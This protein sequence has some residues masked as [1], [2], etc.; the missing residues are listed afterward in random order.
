MGMI[1]DIQRTCTDDGPGVRTTVFFKGCPLRCRWCH[2]PESH[3]VCPQQYADTGEMIGYDAA[4][5]QVVETV[6]ADRAYYEATGGGMTLSGGEP[7]MQPEFART[8]LL[9]AKEQGIHTC[10]ETCGY[11]AWQS[12]EEILPYTDLFLFDVKTTPEKH[13]HWTGVSSRRI[14]DNL[15]SLY[16]AGAQILLRCPI[17]P[18]VN[19]TETHFAFL[20]GLL[21][22]YPR[23]QGMQMMPY[24]NLGVGKAKRLHLPGMLELS[25]PSAE[26]IAGWRKALGCEENNFRPAQ[27]NS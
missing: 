22:K 26:Q 15:D 20:Q 2:N 7:L 1:F 19:D 14:L 6:L 21:E 24:H 12:F 5:E 18:G 27:L 17:I 10:V 16:H 11:A 4:P 8:L 9:L 3:A 13:L 23:L 25:N